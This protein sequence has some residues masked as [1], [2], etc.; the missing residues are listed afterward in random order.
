[1]KWLVS[2]FTL[3]Y[4]LAIR[5]RWRLY[6][7]GLIPTSHLKR[8]VISVGN[9]TMGGAG[10]T[11]ATIALARLLQASGL[12]VSVLLR[13]YR[14][15][16]RGEPLVVSDGQQLLA[17][18]DLAG[19]EAVVLARNLPRAIVAI[20]KNRAD[21]GEWV[22]KHFEVDVHLLDDGFQHLK[23]HRDLN[24]L[25]VD[26]TNP[27]GGGL[28]PLGRLR[29]PLDAVSRAD[30][31][32]LTRTELTGGY[33]RMVEEIL[34]IKPHIPYFVTKQRLTNAWALDRPA[35]STIESWNGVSVFAIAGIANPGQFFRTLQ[36]HGIQL[37]DCWTFPDHHRYCH[38]DY[39]RIQS[40]CQ[41][42]QMTTVMTTEKDA[43]KLDA[44]ALAPLSVV[45]VR[46]TFEFDN[47]DLLR[48]ILTECVGVPV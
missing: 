32:I 16:H 23:L 34:K 14:G 9:L 43:V 28:P 7:S 41:R 42:L 19:D 3:L 20:S 10:K 4:A 48:K 21:A 13:G 35:D 30:A 25:V 1:M 2:P 46:L 29:E 36:R 18:A 5:L 37:A 40:R 15:S 26:A 8:P 12:R 11:P 47:T 22:E 38:D 33:S 24:L 45:A 44:A 17:T 6:S 39:R 31:V 27:Y